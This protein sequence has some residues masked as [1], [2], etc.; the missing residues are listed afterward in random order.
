VVDSI[1]PSRIP[2]AM[3]G[4]SPEAGKREDY[5]GILLAEF[6]PALALDAN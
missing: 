2:I 1:E 3:T 6:D 5:C 4:R